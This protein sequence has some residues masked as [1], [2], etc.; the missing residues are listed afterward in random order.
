MLRDRS[1]KRRQ[2]SLTVTIRADT[3]TPR[4]Q[5]INYLRTHSSGT[6]HLVEDVLLAAYMPLVLDPKKG[7]DD[8]LH[9]FGK[10]Q[11]Y[12][13]T[14][15]QRCGIKVVGGP[16]QLGSLVSSGFSDIEEESEKKEVELD[17]E[18]ARI[19]KKFLDDMAM[20]GL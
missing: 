16:I 17:P 20:M 6:H 9:Y 7:K 2:T 5:M 10:L 1:K 13:Q 14:V 12:V 18:Q 11:G 8:I 4:G 19:H 3:D 15:V